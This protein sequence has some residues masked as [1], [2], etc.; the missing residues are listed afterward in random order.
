MHTRADILAKLNMLISKKQND[1]L[2][3]KIFIKIQKI[4]PLISKNLEPSIK[5]TS[6]NLYLFELKEDV[7]RLLVEK[8]KQKYHFETV[9]HALEQ[10]IYGLIF[11][12]QNLLNEALGKLSEIGENDTAN[13][14]VSDCITQI[15][16]LSSSSQPYFSSL[17]DDEEKPLLKCITQEFLPLIKREQLQIEPIITEKNKTNS[18]TNVPITSVSNTKPTTSQPQKRES[19]FLRGLFT[20]MIT[21]ATIGAGIGAL[22]TLGILTAPLDIFT[23]PILAIV[24][25][26]AG[27]AGYICFEAARTL[28]SFLKD[29]PPINNKQTQPTSNQAGSSSTVLRH[30]GSEL[31]LSRSERQR[32]EKLEKWLQDAIKEI[33]QRK[34]A[35]S[36]IYSNYTALKNDLDEI[37]G[38]LRN[39]IIGPIVNNIVI[40]IK[41]HKEEIKRLI[42]PM[43]AESGKLTRRGLFDYNTS[44]SADEIREEIRGIFRQVKL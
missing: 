40:R 32:L 19:S 2:Y 14:E 10:A 21:G 18:I 25:A 16:M 26:A 6:L 20:S 27:I 42:K 11:S 35:N 38:A 5:L 9:P 13:K 3:Q 37:Q 12:D 1:R 22:P 31:S 43:P 4:Y 41:D 34:F 28:N 33:E 17:V 44:Y 23:I 7:V 8:I 15:E 24:G 29:K 30:V 36:S 39:K